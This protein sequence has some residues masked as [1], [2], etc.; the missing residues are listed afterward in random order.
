MSN[1]QRRRDSTDELS[2]VGGLKILY[3]HSQGRSK[4]KPAKNFGKS[5]RGRSQAVPIFSMAP[6]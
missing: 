3:A 1:T 4:Q 2:R 6:I 5:S